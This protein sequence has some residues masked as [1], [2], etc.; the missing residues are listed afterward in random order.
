[1]IVDLNLKVPSLKENV[2]WFM[3]N[4]NYCIVESSND[5]APGS[6]EQ[7]MTRGTLSLENFGNRICSRDF[8]D[9][10]HT[11]SASEKDK[12]RS[13]GCSIVMKCN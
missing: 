12:V 5:G 2:I 13:F 11:L 8:H 9:I 6:S 3:T 1:M 7:T 4:A 10:L